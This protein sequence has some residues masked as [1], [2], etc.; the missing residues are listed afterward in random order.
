MPQSPNLPEAWK[1]ELGID[2]KE[3]HARY[4]HTIGNLT[5]TGY[6]SELSNHSFLQKRVIDGGF[7]HS[8]L[9][10]NKS[11]AWRPHWNKETIEERA[12]ILAKEACEIWGLPAL[13]A[14]KLNK[15]TVK[16]SKK[17][18]LE[19]VIGPVMHPLAG[20]VPENFKIIQSKEK[21]FYL[22]RNINGEWI[23]YGNGKNPWSVVS[24]DYAKVFLQDKYQKN[25]MPLGIGGEK[26]SG[27]IAHG[28]DEA[29][30]YEEYMLA[31]NTNSDKEYTLEGHHFLQGEILSLFEA[32]RKQ[33]LN[34][35]VEV[36]EEVKKR[37]IAFKL[38]TNFVD[39]QP[40][41][42]SLRLWLN[43]P[44]EEIDDPKGLCKDVTNIGH[45]GNGGIE[46]RLNSFDQIE[47]V[48]DL[49]RQSFNYHNEDAV[50]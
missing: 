21:R 35:D 14:E 49:I 22:F 2:W 40:Q 26:I 37:Y 17:A 10:L 4:L 7:D 31:A 3:I 9:K 34:L 12:E 8:P 28:K 5:L 20:F 23:Q 15:I 41:K 6:N 47:D 25:E 50:A 48:M 39:I 19:E 32:L 27:A 36:L 43:M 46:I 42:V 38:D 33:I 29:K 45:Y 16:K 11:V 24:W 13:S 44:F 18:F 30:L 1:Q